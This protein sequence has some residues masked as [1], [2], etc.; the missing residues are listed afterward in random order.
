MQRWTVRTT[1]HLIRSKPTYTHTCTSPETFTP[2]S[3]QLLGRPMRAFPDLHAVT[4]LSYYTYLTRFCSE[5][6][7]GAWMGKPP[8]APPV[9][10]MNMGCVYS[11]V[12][13]GADS[14]LCR[15]ELEGVI[16]RN[17]PHTYI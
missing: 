11:H 5:G 8:V 1:A 9:L 7:A 17:T 12:S 6:A 2:L 15:V 3:L 10:A 16:Q 4:V 13:A 14:Q